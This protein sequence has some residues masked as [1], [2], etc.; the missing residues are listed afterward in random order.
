MSKT[1]LIVDDEA[2]VRTFLSAVL[3]K[4]GYHPITA[5]NG[6]AGLEVARRERPALVVL[7]LMMPKQS[8][9]DFYRELTGSG[10]FADT[11]I[12]VAS[13]LSARDAVVDHAVAVFDKP[14]NP[15]EFIAAVKQALGD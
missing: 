6:V 1:V 4:H 13:G 10:E 11:P 3:K 9:P 12:I 8:G 14:I 2:D 15:D 7:D 5:E